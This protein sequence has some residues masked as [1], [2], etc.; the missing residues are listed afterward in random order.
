MISKTFNRYIWLLNTLLQR[1]RMTF[2]EISN[3]WSNNSIGEGSPL[4]LRTFHA[5][6]EAIAELFGVEI[7]C[8]TSTYEYYIPSTES[9]RNDKMRQW[10]LNSFTLSNMIEAG[11]NM[12]ERIL[13]ED[14]PQGTEYLQTVIEAMQ[15][16]VELQMDYQPYYGHRATYHMH[17][18]AMKVYHQRWY[19][20]GLLKEKNAIRNIALDRV[21]EMETTKTPFLLPD[22]F[23]AEA[24]Y[25]NTVGIFVNEQLQPQKVLL[26]AYGIQVEYMRSV[27]LHSSQKEIATKYQVYSDFQY[28]LCLT[29]ELTSQL[30][31]M[32][33]NVE[34]LE[35][36]ELRETLCN[37]IK[38]MQERY[39][40]NVK[41]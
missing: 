21:L 4:A 34:V 40:E 23:D 35:P 11:H 16:N 14:I 29:P 7:K 36:Q 41:R 20:V 24:Y 38:K 19:V 10:L 30:L 25:A 5:H 32:G 1:K 17:P 33:E 27:P 2:E 12:K 13:F 6:H 22:D 15:E 37:R 28:K 18:Y 3:K 39:M 9:L 26:R 8:D 31:A